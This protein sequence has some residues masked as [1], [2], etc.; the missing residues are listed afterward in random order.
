MFARHHSFVLSTQ[1]I[2]IDSKIRFFIILICLS[3]GSHLFV[4]QMLINI[5][6]YLPV[7]FTCGSPHKI[8]IANKI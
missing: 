4:L 3:H 1:Y 7:S 2:P 6:Y 8:V 5:E